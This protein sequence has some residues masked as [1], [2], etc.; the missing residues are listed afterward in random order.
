MDGIER[1][2]PTFIYIKEF[3]NK[4]DPYQYKTGNN[5]NIF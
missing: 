2:N 3:A 5:E 4:T 1:T